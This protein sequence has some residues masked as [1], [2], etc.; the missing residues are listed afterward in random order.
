MRS[1]GPTSRPTSRITVVL[2]TIVI[3]GVIAGTA[4]A[5]PGDGAGSGSGS[6]GDIDM[7]PDSGSGSGSGSATAPTATGSD[8]AP[9]IVKDPKVAK[10]WLSAA[11]QLVQKG[12]YFTAR[13]KPDDA[14]AQYDNAVTAYQHAIEA[15]D[16]VTVNYQLALVEDKLGALPEAYAYLKLVID[17]QPPVKPDVLKKA[18]TKLD[19][20][21]GKVGIVTFTVLPEGVT[22]SIA[23]K[24]YGDS[25]LKQPIVLMPGTYTA[26]FALVGYQPKQTE[27][28]VEAGGGVEKKIELEPV[29]IK[30][31]PHVA[32]TE[33]EPAPV[34][35]KPSKVPWIAGASATGLFTLGAVIFGAS[36][37]SQHSAYVDPTF[38]KKERADAQ[39]LGRTMAHLCDGAIVLSVASAAFTAYWYHW[40]YQKELDAPPSSDQPR[41][42]PKVDM[43]P[44]VQPDGG[45]LAAVGSF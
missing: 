7:D 14:K 32:E 5:A 45:G 33:P 23:D 11:Q 2:A 36:A 19:D 34:A 18:Q 15:G 35:P 10:K 3:A 29:P 1:R 28:K 44:W 39:S 6:G 13:K 30:I 31:S 16:D 26:S 25:P 42:V 27:L 38:T 8:A 17:A 9:A 40:K 43:V 20:I 12:D 24:E 41:E 37:I 4:A 21:T 22:V